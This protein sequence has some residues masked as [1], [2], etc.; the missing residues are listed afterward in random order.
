MRPPSSLAP[1]GGQCGPGLIPST[2]QSHVETEQNNAS[3]PK[4]VLKGAVPKW[5]GKGQ[6]ED[7]KRQKVKLSKRGD[8]GKEKGEK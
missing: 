6:E 5:E 7:E 3:V 2:E 8:L 4:L 1:S